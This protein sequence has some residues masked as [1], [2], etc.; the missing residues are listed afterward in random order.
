MNKRQYKPK[1]ERRPTEYKS[2]SRQAEHGAKVWESL[3]PEQQKEKMD[4]MNKTREKYASEK[5][6]KYYQH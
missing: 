1:S 5:K 3:T 6:P 4:K 2:L